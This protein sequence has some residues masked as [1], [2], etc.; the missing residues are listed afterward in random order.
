MSFAKH[1]LLFLLSLNLLLPLAAQSLETM[2]GP[3]VDSVTD[4]PEVSEFTV[5]AER[6]LLF[7]NQENGLLY[8]YFALNHYDSLLSLG[9]R[10]NRSEGFLSPSHLSVQNRQ[11]L[12][13]LDESAQTIFL[14]TPSFR[15]LESLDFLS[16]SGLSQGESLYPL[17]FD[18]SG[19]GELF[20][21]NQWDNKVYK[22]NERGETERSFGGL[23][24]GEGSLYE[25][26][27]LQVSDDNLVFVSERKGDQ[28]KVFD[29]Y[30]RYRF[31]VTPDCSFRWDDFVVM[32]D[33]L[34]CWGEEKLYW[35]QLST[36]KNAELSVPGLQSL[37]LDRDFLYLLKENTVHLYRLSDK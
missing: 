5:D 2:F 10:G 6:N 25:P 23:D 35:Q 22:R 14:L 3:L 15:L 24:Y 9:G 13:L 34:I 31:R 7:V 16:L 11:T 20:I 21:L 37:A 18:V 27:H 12:Y 17:S 30:G 29:L 19:I 1:F 26:D 8:K 4:I 33:L 32:S 28:F 36:G